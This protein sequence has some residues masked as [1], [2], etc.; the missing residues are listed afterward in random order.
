MLESEQI[1]LERA[2]S[3][4]EIP[5]RVC[6]QL[7]ADTPRY[8]QWHVHHENHMSRVA[9]AKRREQQI[10]KLR[11]VAVAQI[12]RA[13]LVR[14]LRDHRI[15]GAARNQTLHEFYGITDSRD[16][17][18]AEHRQYLLA[19]S[20]QLCASDILELVNDQPGLD[21]L[22]GYELA[23]GQY[24]SMFCD[25][26]RAVRDGHPY[27]LAAL[28]PEV[29]NSAERWRL[30]ILANR[31]VPVRPT[32]FAVSSSRRKPVTLARAKPALA[33]TASHIR[34]A[35]PPAEEGLRGRLLA[36]TRSARASTSVPRLFGRH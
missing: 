22:R 13:A 10:L 34:P 5:R 7:L 32:V 21:L 4:E 14:Y 28:V 31:T 36:L 17:A 11:A 15:T 18:L 2:I 26:A 23:Y 20:T 30:D 8:S 16:S 19:A 12:H 6:S 1:V 24:F 3:G 35:A 29:R 9:S 27:L 33:I 25:Q